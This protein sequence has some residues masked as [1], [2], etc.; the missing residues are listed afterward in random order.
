MLM[1]YQRRA[2]FKFSVIFDDELIK[3][4]PP[5]DFEPLG[6]E[7]LVSIVNDFE[8]GEWRYGKFF[9]FVLNNIKETALTAT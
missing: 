4:Y 5:C 1:A 6:N 2:D 7:T 8:E 3:D 9:N